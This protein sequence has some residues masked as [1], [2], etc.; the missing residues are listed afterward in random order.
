MI[1]AMPQDFRLPTEFPLREALGIYLKRV[2]IFL[3]CVS[4][5]LLAL[6]LIIWIASLP[7]VGL[8]IAASFGSIVIA[9][10]LIRDVVARQAVKGAIRLSVLDLTDEGWAVLRRMALDS[11]AV[12]W[13]TLR[14]AAKSP[15]DEEW[16]VE[17]RAAIRRTNKKWLALRRAS[18]L[19]QLPEQWTAP[20][21]SDQEWTALRLTVLGLTDEQWTD[22]RHVANSRSAVEWIALRR[23]AM[24][25]TA[26][27][28]TALRRAVLGLADEQGTGI[29][30][31]E[32]KGAMVARAYKTSTTLSSPISRLRKK[33]SRKKPWQ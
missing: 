6:G 32:T 19:R 5:S 11:T 23:A 12:E 1:R 18:L 29:P 2:G 13:R 14:Q 25:R 15:T 21:Q 9:A 8:K 17:Q 27:E 20:R 33:L 24:R 30:P 10:L 22:L 7:S 4:V 31:A 28:W 3:G 16:L 26:V